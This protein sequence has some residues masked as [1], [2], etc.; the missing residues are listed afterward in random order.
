[1]YTCLVHYTNIEYLHVH[2]II[3]DIVMYTHTHT[4][5]QDL[6][7]TIGFGVLYLFACIAWS[8]GVAQLN[9][10]VVG[11]LESYASDC[12]GCENARVGDTGSLQDVAQPVI[13]L[14]H[15]MMDL[16]LSLSLPLPPFL[17]LFLLNLHNKKRLI[18]QLLPLTILTT[19]M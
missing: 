3:H 13:S 17:H 4:Y 16:S 11:R 9:G 7:F 18:V 6:F 14:V 8:A 1:M 15:I 5:T 10:Y 12:F 2:N 19:I